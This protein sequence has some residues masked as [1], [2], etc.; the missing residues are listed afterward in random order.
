M[1]PIDLALQQWA[2][3]FTSM[4]QS[5]AA[6]I[7]LLF[8]VITTAADRRPNEFAKV[9]VYIT[10]TAIYF[11]SVLAIGELATIPT[12]TRLSA[13][14]CFCLVALSGLVYAGCLGVAHRRSKSYYER[15]DLINYAVIPF[16][17]YALLALGGAILLH[18]IQRGLG[19]VAAGMILLLMIAIRNSWAMVVNIVYTRPH[20]DTKRGDV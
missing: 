7:G 14:A 19:F 20:G 13:A 3:F 2:N 16:A 11:A 5:G 10:P 9:H 15:V 1:D 12:L 4:S 17:G 6:L 8:V 18:D